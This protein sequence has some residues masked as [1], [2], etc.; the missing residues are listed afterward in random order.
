MSEDEPRVRVRIIV[1]GRVQGVFFRASARDEA[2]RLGIGG[3]ARN[4]PD[5][6]VL[7]EAEGPSRAVARFREWC[8]V[9]PPRANVEDIDVTPIAIRGER[10]FTVG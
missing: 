6:S 5:G 7:I 9:G 3:F 4:Q 8:A 1:S 10:E 2:R